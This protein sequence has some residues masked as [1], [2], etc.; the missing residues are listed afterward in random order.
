[1]SQ[2]PSE[3]LT[4]AEMACKDDPDPAK[5]TPYPAIWRSDRAVELAK[6]FERVRE[7][8]GFPLIVNSGYRTAVYNDRI[9]GA[10]K[11][12]H[13]E[14]RALDLRPVPFTKAN[15]KA[16]KMAA[17]KA[18]DEGLFRGLGVYPGFIHI[19]TRRGASTDDPGRRVTWVNGTRD[20]DGTI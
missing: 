13:V 10:A 20:L 6:A 11:S 4:W 1:M 12:Q 2:G 18:R 9:G 15:L 7:L 16:L 8:C 5:R 14:G 19:D 3:H 17:Y